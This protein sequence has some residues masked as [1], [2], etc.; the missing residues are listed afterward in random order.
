MVAGDS[1]N[2]RNMFLPEVFKVAVENAIPSLKDL[3]DYIAPSNND[4]GVAEAV[5]RFVLKEEV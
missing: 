3:A 5:R 2:D 4:D 1:D